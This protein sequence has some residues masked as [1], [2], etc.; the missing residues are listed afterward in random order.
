MKV[1]LLIL[2]MSIF[3]LHAENVLSQNVFVTISLN[4]VPLEKVLNTIEKQTNYL[5][6]IN[7][8]VNTGIK[9]SV[10]ARNEKIQDVLSKALK[11]TK[12]NYTVDGDY[13]VLSDRQKEDN[14]NQVSDTQQKDKI[15]G[16]VVDENGDPIIGVNVLIKG[17]SKGTI[18][19]LKGE[20]Q[21]E[22]NSKDVLLL[23][24][25]G[26]QSQ[27]VTVGTKRDI[28]IQMREDN[29]ALEEVVVIGYG[30]QKRVSVTGSIA[31]TKGEELTKQPTT[32]VVNTL[33]GR[34][35]GLISYQTSGEPGY[36]SATLLIRGA[37]TTGD[38]SPLVVVDGV[39][40]R[41]GSLERI[42]ANDIESITILKDASAAIYG[43]RAA[44]GV[45][46]VTTKKGKE[47]KTT[48]TYNGNF[49]ISNPAVLPKMCH[50]WQYAQLINEINTTIQGT[51]ASYSDD[52]IE[53]Y[54][55]GTDP[56]N[57]PDVD[58]LD[59]MLK[60]S[61]QTQHNVQVSG[62]GKIVSYFVSG[63]YQYQDNY[64]KK[65]TSDFS[66]YS[67][68]SNIDINA[69]KNLK[70]G[71]NMA[72]RHIDRNS[73]YYGS[74]D[75]WRYLIKYDPKYNIKWPGTD[76][77]TLASQDNFN[78]VTAVD[79][80]MGY[81]INDGDYINADLTANWDLSFLTNGLSAA[82][83]AY[84]DRT[85]THYKQFYKKFYLYDK[86][87]EN[88]TAKGYGPSNASL[89]QN[90]SQT[91]GITFNARVNY[92][93]TFNDVHALSAFVAY[94]QH[95]SRYDYLKAYRQDYVST[96]VD[97]L[98]AGSS[99]SQ[100]NDGTASETARMN[101][102]G[103]MDYAYNSRYMLQFNWRYDGSENFPKNKR[104]G[105]FPGVSMGWRISEE[106]FWKKN[107]SWMDYLKIRA[108]W[109]QMGN[110]A[111]DAFQYLETYTFD[112]AAIL[113]G[114]AQTG[115]VKEGT[116]NSNIT[117][118]VA[119]TYNVGLEA[120]FLTHFNFE[121]D[122]FKT[123]RKKVLCTRSAAI[124]DYSGLDLPDENIGK[125]S[126]YGFETILGYSNKWNDFRLSVNGNLSYSKNKIDYI[127]EADTYD[128]QKITGNSIGTN[129][130]Y[131][132]MYE[133]T[134]IMRTQE[135]YDNSPHFSNATVGDLKFRDV[136]GDEVIDADDKVRQNKPKVPR[137]MYGVTTDLQYKN[138]GLNMLWQGTAQVWQYTFM[139]AGIIGNFTEDFYNNRWTADN[140]NAKYPKV[141]NRDYTPSG[142]GD[143][144]N[145]FWLKN[146]SY[147]RLKSIELS[148]TLP[149][150]SLG[151]LGNVFSDLRFSV[152]GYN[153][154]TFTGIKNLDPETSDTASGQG[155]TGWSTPQ[156][157]S[158]SFGIHLSL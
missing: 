83:G 89:S 36:D 152:A 137:I 41:A 121:L 103:R 27:E 44:N 35:P 14:S 76:Y 142:A 57:Y 150:K 149:K 148:Y 9:V 145:T 65:G 123:N 117:W 51:N 151:F 40:D 124:P 122:I 4:N 101:F 66:Q 81:Q 107:V 82:G 84:F 25:I 49:A 71:V 156:A 98:F 128:W 30:V 86:D 134:G 146:A 64:Y 88:Y 131:F 78:P 13:I 32:N 60:P 87:G 53:L 17:T 37:S 24:Y 31:V 5:F 54:K 38:S 158:I 108:S 91:L 110:D 21:L 104:W 109:G 72:W 69:H 138:W 1:T 22:A 136:N 77:P 45:I 10:N 139:E 2:F 61:L 143:Y 48:V 99:D 132:L 106:D 140:P 70:L 135:D 63:G 141:Y 127:A 116:A 133:A 115:I 79:G 39:A 52:E 33:G 96:E 47:G 58:A 23:T 6:V 16:Y 114:E 68:R 125:C 118:E 153:L 80:S 34:L 100:T 67:L 157:K 147:L 59:Y 120:R 97:Q 93:K 92:E 28:R 74:T 73:P 15:K 20:F 42:D 95:T 56:L 29:K 126:A 43:S 12:I 18:T 55:N 3:G 8:N 94:E 50:S 62:S 144:R 129:D 111:V 26:Y 105:F 155:W 113:N 112:N 102:F 90:M 130:D 11:G 85:D 119:N 7:A 19:D 154:F 75:I 46:L